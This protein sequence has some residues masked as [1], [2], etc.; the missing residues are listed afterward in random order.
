[1]SNINGLSSFLR[2]KEFAVNV[3]IIH[4]QIWSLN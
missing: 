3:I 1:M 2:W 4:Y